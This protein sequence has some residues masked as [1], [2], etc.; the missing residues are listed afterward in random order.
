MI[1]RILER[2]VFENLGLKLGI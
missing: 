2:N 1:R